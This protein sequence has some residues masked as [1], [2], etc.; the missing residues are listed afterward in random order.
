MLRAAG[1][2][3]LRRRPVRSPSNRIAKVAQA[4]PTAETLARF[5]A[6]VEQ[7]AHVEAIEAYY[8]ADATMQENMAAPRVG[9]DALVANEARALSRARSVHSKCIGPV[10]VNGDHVVI[11]WHFRFEGH[12]GTVRD[13]EELA[14]QRWQ[15]ERILAEQFFYDPAQFVPRTPAPAP[16]PGT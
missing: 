14:Y 4:M 7:G 5:I 13:L 2:V 16:G 8:H 6:R 11:R 3:P 1:P 15:G 10:F 9:R 12:D